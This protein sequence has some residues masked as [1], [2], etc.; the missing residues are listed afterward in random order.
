[1]F[2]LKK[3]S[4]KA[5][6]SVPDEKKENSGAFPRSCTKSGW[7]DTKMS[8]EK[9]WKRRYF[10]LSNNFLLCAPTQYATKLET[11]IPLEGCESG[12][13]TNETMIFKINMNNRHGHHHK[14]YFKA[15]N[16]KECQKWQQHIKKASKLKIEDLYNVGNTL[17]VSDTQTS[18]VVEAQHRTR[19]YEC[20]I[21][22]ITKKAYNQKMLNKEIKILKTL[23][24]KYIVQLLDVFNTKKKIYIIMERYGCMSRLDLI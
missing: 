23:D 15:P 6:I 22:I 21:K 7:L 1:M 3:H 10:V 13:K 24:S 12:L 14:I 4:I 2:G 11:I 9:H 20:A 17:S 18:K 8:T 16:D 19:N 5:S